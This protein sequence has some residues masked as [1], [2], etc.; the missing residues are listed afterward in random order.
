MFCEILYWYYCYFFYSE[1][2]KKISIGFAQV[3][4]EHWVTFGYFNS[5]YPSVKKAAM[6]F[7]P[8][9]NYEI[10]NKYLASKE[11]LSKNSLRNVGE[12]YRGKIGLHYMDTITY[13]YNEVISKK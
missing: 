9:L 11:V 4:I 5:V 1:R 6:V 13:F 12:A 2:M 8:V 7:D 10:C 3:Q